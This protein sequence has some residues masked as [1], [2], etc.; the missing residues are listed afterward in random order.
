MRTWLMALLLTAPSA[1]AASTTIAVENHSRGTLVLELERSP[2]GHEAQ[3]AGVLPPGRATAAVKPASKVL[4]PSAEA[5]DHVFELRY[6]DEAGD[7]CRFR[8]IVEPHSP[9]F[10]RIVPVADPIGRGRC[11]ASTGSTRGDFVFLA[12]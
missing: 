4:S 7:G 5:E 10:A 12:R 1:A 11:E 8:A 3:L 9:A 2:K 6:V